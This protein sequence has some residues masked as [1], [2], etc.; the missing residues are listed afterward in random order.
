VKKLYIFIVQKFIVYRTFAIKAITSR[1]SLP[2][3]N[4]KFLASN[5][6]TRF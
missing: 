4:S 2:D 3:I 1:Q 6:F 5:N